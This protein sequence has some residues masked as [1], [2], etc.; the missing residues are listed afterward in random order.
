MAQKTP[1]DKPLGCC[2]FA[3]GLRANSA[4][5]QRRESGLA[6]CTTNFPSLNDPFLRFEKICGG[7]K[8]T[9]VECSWAKCGQAR[10]Q[11]EELS[12]SLSTR[13]A[14]SSKT[15]HNSYSGGSGGFECVGSSDTALCWDLP[16]HRK[17]RVERA[18]KTVLS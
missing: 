17:V 8:K 18:R 15:I 4:H 3:S 2:F 11:L 14:G 6:A 10:G 1:A 12:I 9:I 13:S 16:N 5:R 7:I